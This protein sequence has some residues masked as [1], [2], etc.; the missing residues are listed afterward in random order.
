MKK[1]VL[2]IIAA[3]SVVFGLTAYA[4]VKDP[5]Q[6]QEVQE[7]DQEEAGATFIEQTFAQIDPAVS[8]TLTLKVEEMDNR[9]PADAIANSIVQYEGSIGRVTADMSQK[10]FTIEYDSS[11]LKEE[12]LIKTVK[13]TG[14]NVEKI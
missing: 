14:Y 4:L 9:A 2:I 12:E 3:I 7:R 13:A 1:S 10:V 8:K 11:K 5:P 6:E